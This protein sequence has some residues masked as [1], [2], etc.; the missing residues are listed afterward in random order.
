MTVSVFGS[1]GSLNFLGS[2]AM[3]VET[4]THRGNHSCLQ[5]EIRPATAFNFSKELMWVCI[6]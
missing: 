2:P 6:K 1:H 5:A 3:E 4:C